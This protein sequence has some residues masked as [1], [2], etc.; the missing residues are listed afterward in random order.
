MASSLLPTELGLLLLLLWNVL[1]LATALSSAVTSSP[2]TTASTPLS[3]TTG[4]IF[5]GRLL[6]QLVVSVGFI[7]LIT[8]VLITIVLN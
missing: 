4:L 5:L 2:T 1:L 6:K 7:V 8:I 3:M